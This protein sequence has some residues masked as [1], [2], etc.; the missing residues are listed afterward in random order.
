MNQFLKKNKTV[1]VRS[2]PNN[3]NYQQLKDS[4]KSNNSI[5]DGL[6]QRNIEVLEDL[7]PNNT[8]FSVYLYDRNGSLHL[9]ES[10]FDDSTFNKVFN[11]VD[12][13]TVKPSQS[14]GGSVDYKQKYYK[15]KQKYDQLNNVVTSFKGLS[16]EQ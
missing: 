15:Y 13:I 6:K 14:G 12:K 11:V 2:S 4:I 16:H 1:I 9:N 3:P 8:D 7:S 5:V 10:G